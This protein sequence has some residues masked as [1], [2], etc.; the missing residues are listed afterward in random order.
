[1]K[2]INESFV[3]VG[4]GRSVPLAQQTCRNHCPVCFTSLH[5]DG[6]IPGERAT[7]CHG[8]MLPIQYEYHPTKTRILFVCTL[9]GKR[10]RN[11]ASGD[12]EIGSLPE[13][14]VKYKEKTYG[15]E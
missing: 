6:E 1:M 5:V 8:V 12:D 4:C 7:N 2:K 15:F 10:H 3:C 11:K 14:I 13:W 9:C